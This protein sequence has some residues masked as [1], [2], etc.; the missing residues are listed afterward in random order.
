M[1]RITD[2]VT[3]FQHLGVPVADLDR[4]VDFYRGLGLEEMERCAIEENGGT[5]RVAFLRIGGFWLELY[6]SAARFARKDDRPGPIDHLA[7]DVRDVEQAFADAK[8][9]GYQVLEEKPVYLP[10][11]KQGCKYFMILGPDGERVEFN[12]TM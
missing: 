6:Q 7:L 4:S 1:S 10:L 3:G 11:R 9:A 12:Q 2:N 5:T 8:A